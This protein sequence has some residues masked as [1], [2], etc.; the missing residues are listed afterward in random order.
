MNV[1]AGFSGGFSFDYSSRDRHTTITIWDGLDGTGNRLATTGILQ[2]TPFLCREG[3]G[4]GGCWSLVDDLDFAGIARSVTF[5][6]PSQGLFRPGGA[7]DNITFEMNAP[8]T[9]VPEPAVLGIFSLG[10]LLVGL[11]AGRRRLRFT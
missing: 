4:V 3:I 7:F 8:V 2:K 9:A 5:D 6:T 1:A 10:V 11:F